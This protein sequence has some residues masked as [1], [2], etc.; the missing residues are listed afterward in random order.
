MSIVWLAWSNHGYLIVERRN[1]PGGINKCCVQR[2]PASQGRNGTV[3]HFGIKSHNS[4]KGKK[5]WK[6]CSYQPGPLNGG[7]KLCYINFTYTYYVIISTQFANMWK[8]VFKRWLSTVV[9]SVFLVCS[10]QTAQN[11][12]TIFLSRQFPN[13]VCQEV[14]LPFYLFKM[15]MSFWFGQRV[16]MT[17]SGM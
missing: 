11:Q 7:D 4:L 6:L 13:L 15:A 1:V 14:V 3:I 17:P 10:F 16:A 9:R 8:K 5:T 2:W 12:Q